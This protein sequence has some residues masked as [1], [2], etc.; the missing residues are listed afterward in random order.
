MEEEL[1]IKASQL[2]RVWNVVRVGALYVG[3]MRYG[4]LDDFSGW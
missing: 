3:E 4:L 2:A 1:G